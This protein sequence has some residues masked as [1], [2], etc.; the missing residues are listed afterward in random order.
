MKTLPHTFPLGTT[1]GWWAD[2]DVTVPLDQITTHMHIIGASGS[3]KSRYL[4]FLYLALLRQGIPATLIDP[5]GQLARLVLTHLVASGVYRSDEAFE[6]VVYLDLPAA[7]RAGRFLPLNLL[8]Q[9]GSP[10]TT[11]NHVLDAMHRAWPA[12]AEGAA[13]RFD[14]LVQNGIKV[15]ISNGLPLPALTHLLT[16]ADFRRR[17]LAAEADPDVAAFFRDQYDRLGDRERLDYADATL[18]R[19]SLLTFSPILKYSLGQSALG[20]DF[21]RVMDARQSLIINLAIEDG[22]AR[23]LLGCLLTV[24]AEQG[25]LSRAALPETEAFPPYFLLLDEAFEHTAQTETALSKMLSQ[26]R[27]FGLFL[28]MAHQTWSQA[29]ERLRGGLQNVGIRVVF[30]LDYEDAVIS[31]THIGRVDTAAIKHEATDPVARSRG[32]PVY[33][34]LSEQWAQWTQAIQ[35]LTPANGRRG[36][37][38]EAFIKLRAQPTRKVTTPR[39]P[40]PPVDAQHLAAIERTYL[41]TY[42]RSQAEIEQAIRQQ[43]RVPAPS[44]PQTRRVTDVRRRTG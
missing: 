28:V 35:D 22:K 31:A 34:P 44:P 29:P 33:A 43:Q 1:R 38:G 9:P 40:T 10:T 26:S 3:G 42:F 8:A 12:L 15:L 25:A 30:N 24:A 21:R 19:I 4:A 11:A 16:N 41:A 17:C 20:I 23:P 14:K 7:E 13:P 5:H 39:L 32:H 2:R 18:S 27:K 37:P 36:L 6:R